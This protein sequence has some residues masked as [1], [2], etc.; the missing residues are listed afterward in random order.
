MTPPADNESSYANHKG[1]HSVILQA[2]CVNDRSFTDIFCG[3]P[4]R[5]NDARVFRNSN[6]YQ[7]LPSLVGEN[8]IL[9]DGAYPL[10]RFVMKPYRETVSTNKGQKK[11]NY[12]L[13]STRTVIEHAFGMLKGRF[14]RLQ[15]INMRSIEYVVKS[16]ITACVLHN[17]CI[18][19]EDEIEECYVGAP[20][21]DTVS[22]NLPAAESEGTLKRI[23]LTRQIANM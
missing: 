21:E 16:V 4:G 14:R 19:N 2:V 9:G 5:V 20:D 12:C 10:S 22:Y 15:H 23:L 6:L 13:C 3:W 7:N 11:F 17:I 1:F 8:H 18:K